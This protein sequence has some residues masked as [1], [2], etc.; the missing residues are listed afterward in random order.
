MKIAVTGAF[1]Y[2]GKYITQRLLA[3]GDE[4]ITL[5]G[6][7]NNPDPFNGKVKA[8]SFDFDEP[9]KLAETLNGVE[10]L[11][12]TYWV[13]FSHGKNTHEQAVSN[14]LTLI[15]A[16]EQAGVK[17]IVHTSI[18]NPSLDSHLPYF[19][20][21]AKLEKAI[22]ASSLGYA[23]LRP[24]VLF[25]DEDI[26]VNNIAW[27]LRKFPLFGLPGNGSYRL[28]PI[29]V[30]DY[31]DLAVDLSTRKE[32]IITDTVGPDI[33]SFEEMVRLI[34]A[35]IERPARLLKMPPKLALWASQI[36][37]AFVGDVVL[38]QDEVD[39]LMEGLLVSSEPPLGKTHLADWLKE[40]NHS[41]GMKYASEMKKHYR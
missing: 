8:Y 17:R 28:Q 25:G 29:F 37:G 7:P 18:T 22:K 5:T 2:T 26:L 12:N 15:R 6:H 1:S 14:T 32:D 40:N 27:L 4:V 33:F 30:E 24:T 13:R 41:V 35:E 16:A 31:A 39:G 36:I 9:D 10:I 11:F 34:A 3:R 19:S 21:K 38:T 23:I 20:G